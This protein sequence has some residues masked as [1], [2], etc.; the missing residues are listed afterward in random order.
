LSPAAACRLIAA[1]TDSQPPRD[2]ARRLAGSLAEREAEVLGCLG[3][4]LPNAQIAARLFLSEATVKG[5]VS[6]LLVKLDY[7]NRTQAGLLA[8]TPASL[9]LGGREPQ[10]D[11][12]GGVEADFDAEGVGDAG[13]VTGVA[14]DD[15]CLVA[16]GGGD[17]DGIDDVGGSGCGAGD[18]CGAA[19]ALVVGEDVAAF[20]DAGDLV[21]GSA[22]PGLGQDDDRDERPD[23]CRGHLV[24]QGEEIGV[25]PLGG[26]QRPG[27]VN[28]GR[29]LSGGPLRLVVEQAGFK[30]ELAGALPGC[31]RQGAVVM[32]VVG[33]EFAGGS[34]VGGVPGGGARF[35]G[36][37]F[38][39]PGRH[40]LALVC[41]GC[42]D[43]LFDL[44]GH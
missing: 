6:R 20:E 38:G 24:V 22:A 23:T 10:A 17:D 18:S 14:G 34:T 30:Q 36:S 13:Q 41:G 31:R 19:G 11:R 28:D 33:D 32:F 5:Y 3:A 42:F 35:L 27:V 4:G 16:D 29:H 25:A 43:R 37:G 9:A 7:A 21:L 12:S 39:E 40:G 15:G 44:G 26:E 2:R 1:S 8:Q